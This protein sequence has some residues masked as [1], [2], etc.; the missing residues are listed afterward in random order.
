MGNFDVVIIFCELLETGMG[1]N[2]WQDGS[3]G[4]GNF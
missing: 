3:E 4:T 2:R 1:K